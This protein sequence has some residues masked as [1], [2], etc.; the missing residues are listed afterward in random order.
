VNS[1]GQTVFET[2]TGLL[3]ETMLEIDASSLTK[4]LYTLRVSSKDGVVTKQ[5][6]IIQ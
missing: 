5:V 6:A 4:G 3:S 2:K 1:L